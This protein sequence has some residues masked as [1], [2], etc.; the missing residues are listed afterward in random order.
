MKHI[1]IFSFVLLLGSN[2]CAQVVESGPYTIYTISEGI[3]HI[4]DATADRPAG[5]KI[6]PDGKTSINN[7]SDMYLVT[8]KERALLIDLSNFLKYDSS[9]AEKLRS[10]VYE[11]TKGRELFITITHNHGDHTGMLPAF[12]EEERAKF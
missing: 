12:R 10:I 9:A 8:G 4:E 5:I 7:S 1:L 3:Y 2:T 6:L 11:R